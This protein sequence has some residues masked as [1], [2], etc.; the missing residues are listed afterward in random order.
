VA[1][2]NP[3]SKAGRKRSAVE[4]LLLPAAS[5]AVVAVASV[6]SLFD[7]RR[8]PPGSRMAPKPPPEPGAESKGLLGRVAN[9]LPFLR[10]VL[11]VHQRYGELGGNQ[12]AASF[13]FSAFLSLFPLL[14]AAVAAVGFIAAGSGPDLTAR[15]A[16]QLGLQGEAA[17]ILTATID[18][19]KSGRKA[20]SIVGFVG[21]LWSG[22]GLVGA[23]QY[24]Y[25]SVWQV[26]DR[27]L[28][29]KVIGLLWLAGAA[30]LFIAGAAATT[31]LRWLPGFLA[32]FGILVGFLLSL[33]LW[34]WTSRI[35][36]NRKIG[37][38]VLLPGAILGAVG[39]EVLKVVGAYYVPRAVASS[40]ALYG[41]LGV[42]FAV[43]AW[44][45][46]FG[47]LVVYSAVLNVV[48]YER[49][50]G[51]VKVLVS[52]PPLEGAQPVATRSGRLV[53]TR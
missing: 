8:R 45:L 26:V 19:A 7:R 9:R 44:L 17:K 25:D 37:W 4:A 10:P 34:L 6:H 3:K 51:T 38:R 24:A 33:A 15:L 1:K 13:T 40:S 23:L 27:G 28:K 47:R 36:P 32:P 52:A 53:T 22:L 18:Q 43:L 39:L 16:K 50:V 31:A 14:L 35:L 2:T 30:V 42:I 41:S 29:D 21:L 20:A 11:A 48:R 46:L 12:L 49:H 5:T